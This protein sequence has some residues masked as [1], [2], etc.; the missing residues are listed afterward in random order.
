MVI[1]KKEMELASIKYLNNN[2]PSYSKADIIVYRIKIGFNRQRRRSWFKIGLGGFLCVVGVVTL[3]IPC[4]SIFLIGAGCSLVVD[5][6][7]DL[8]RYYRKLE[9]KVDLILFRGGLR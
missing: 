3:P 9:R 8:W 2:K 7:F 1:H 6:G 4:G 5:G